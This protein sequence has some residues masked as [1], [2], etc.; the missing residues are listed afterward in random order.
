MFFVVVV[1]VAFK[2]LRQRSVLY[3]WHAIPNH[4]DSRNDPWAWYW[5]WIWISESWDPE[6]GDWGSRS[7][8]FRVAEASIS[9][10]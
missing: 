4:W 3:V 2:G 10:A 5:I 1:S 7:P 8:M 6:T 9:V